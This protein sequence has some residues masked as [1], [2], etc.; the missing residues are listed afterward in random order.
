MT[1]R[2]DVVIAG[3]GP[4][5]S[6]LAAALAARGASVL[7]VERSEYHGARI[8]E[9]LPP[10]IRPA[11]ARLGLG[12]AL[13][14]GHLRSVGIRSTWGGPAPVDRSFLFDPYGTGWHVERNR[15]DRA[16]ATQAEALGATVFTGCEVA[17]CRPGWRLRL[18]GAGPQCDIRAQVV[19]DATGRRASL[20]RRLG[21]R[22][23]ILDRTVAI[24]GVS[25]PPGPDVE[26]PQPVTT[27]E[28]AEEGWWYSAP[29]RDGRVVV[30]CLT[31]SDIC[32][33]KHLA[34]PTVWCD[35][36]ARLARSSNRG[37]PHRIQE[38]TLV[39]AAGN[40]RLDQAWGAGWLATGDAAAAH[41]PLAGDG[42][43]SALTDAPHAAEAVL[44]SCDQGESALAAYTHR[45]EA[46]FDR[47][48]VRAAAFYR[49]E[50]RWP[51]APFW[52]RRHHTLD[53]AIEH[54]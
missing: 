6:G 13:P 3:G 15:F 1:G 37:G 4:A 22:R 51:T 14:D 33:V 39:V 19:V 52:R 44:A 45:Q 20:A 27:I 5:G 29:L 17:D 28:A 47:H 38:K 11:L 9:S 46:D 21:A 2:Y 24:I 50:Q 35:H 32:R 16:L 34:E 54:H 53:V 30:A 42:I 49:R 48:L 18:N 23:L 7:V 8:G 40:S 12:A 41:D 26:Q 25:H 10:A 43:V 36:L 31:D